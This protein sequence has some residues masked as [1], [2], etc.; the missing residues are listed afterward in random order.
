MLRARVQVERGKKQP[1]IKKL[2][3]DFALGDQREGW[4]E[5][6]PKTLTVQ[7]NKAPYKLDYIEGLWE[8]QELDGV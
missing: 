3:L 4:K 1:F 2:G 8:K 6:P 5:V 7:G